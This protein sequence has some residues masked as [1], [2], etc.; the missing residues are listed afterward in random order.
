MCQ[1]YRRT[2]SV[3]YECPHTS[4]LIFQA[5][6]RILIATQRSDRHSARLL[7]MRLIC[8][9]TKMVINCP[10]SRLPVGRE[11]PARLTP[12]R[13]AGQRARRAA[14]AP[15]LNPPGCAASSVA[16]STYSCTLPELSSRRTKASLPITRRAITRP[17][18]A[19]SSPCA[20]AH[21]RLCEF[22]P[23]CRPRD[24]AASGAPRRRMHAAARPCSSCVSCLLPCGVLPSTRRQRPPALARHMPRARAVAELQVPPAHV[25]GA[26]AAQALAHRPRQNLEPVPH[27]ELASDLLAG[28]GAGVA[29]AP[30]ARPSRRQ[31][32]PGSAPAAR[33]PG[34]CA[35]SGTH[36]APART[37][38]ALA[39]AARRP[40]LGRVQAVQARRERGAL[41]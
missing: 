28:C 3:L 34:A 18:T 21:G 17:A 2:T 11:R 30:A 12:P 7:H 5:R 35:Q 33:L 22:A 24:R 10:T 1:A 27:T 20:R 29:N 36:T 41:P 31:A 39:P 38:A 37:L 8:V 15:R 25:P 16:R 14:A 4:T 9:S 40:A 19:T 6:C 13:Q 32:G 26:L 23:R